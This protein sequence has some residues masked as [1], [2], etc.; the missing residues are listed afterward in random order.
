MSEPLAYF[1]TW[2]T[3]RTWLRG[4]K[5]GWVEEKKGHQQPD[6]ELHKRQ[7]LLETPC[8]LDSAQRQI[9]EQTIRDH[10][11]IRGWESYAVNC[12]TNHVHVVVAAFLN[13]DN[14]MEY[15]KSWCTRRLKEQQAQ[16]APKLIARQRWWTE[17][18]STRYL[19][20]ETGLEAAVLYVK[21]AQDRPH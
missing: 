3:Y 17:G 6:E 20:D 8:V 19:N 7:R 13:P 16:S 11:H 10:C 2:T 15:F 12:R 9:V 21:E 4:D 5:R 18:G 14:V 1:L